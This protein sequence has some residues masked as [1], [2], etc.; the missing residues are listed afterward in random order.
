[1]AWLLVAF[2]GLI[3]YAGGLYLLRQCI[4]KE[5]DYPVCRECGYDLR[6]VR[7]GGDAVHTCP[8]CGMTLDEETVQRASARFTRWRTRFLSSTLVVLS[9]FVLGTCIT[10]GVLALLGWWERAHRRQPAP[11]T[12]GCSSVQRVR[13]LARR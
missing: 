1:V 13:Q 12:T 3:G 2:L 11:W 6:G 7:G 4:W 9:S 8:E 10:V 5:A